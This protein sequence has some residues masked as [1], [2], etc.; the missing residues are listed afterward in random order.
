[1]RRVRNQSSQLLDFMYIEAICRQ[2]AVCSFDGATRLTSFDKGY[3]NVI[4]GIAQLMEPENARRLADWSLCEP[5]LDRN[6]FD[7]QNSQKK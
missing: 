5:R 1:M 2:M 4:L 3:W 7:F 6:R